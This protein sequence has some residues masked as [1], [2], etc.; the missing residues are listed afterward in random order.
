MPTRQRIL[1]YLEQRGP[2][3]ARQLATAFG[4]TQANLRHH[5]SALLSEGRIRETSLQK[6]KGRGR[7]RR[8]FALSERSEPN[9]LANLSGV[10]LAELSTKNDIEGESMLKKVA[11]RMLGTNSKPS[12]H[13]SQRLVAAVRH[14][15]PMGYKPHWE[16]R[17][18]VPEIVFGHCPYAAIIDEHPELCRMD[19]HMLEELL[20]VPVEQTAKLQTG[21]QGVPICVFTVSPR[22]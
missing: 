19:L 5:L 6:D 21:P 9:N 15:A 2:A 12:G 8:H 10:L 17:P 22:G 20:G 1:D 16:A 7:P 18:R 11:S 13:I 14:L 3:S 4:M